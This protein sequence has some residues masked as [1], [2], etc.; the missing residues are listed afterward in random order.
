MKS[1]SQN[2][3]KYH[4]KERY[5]KLIPFEI[6]EDPIPYER[7]LVRKVKRAKNRDIQ[8]IKIE[9]SESEIP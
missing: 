2:S 4:K 1:Y 6:E 7:R 5:R 9:D 8:D 3:G